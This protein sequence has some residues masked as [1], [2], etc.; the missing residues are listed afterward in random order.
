MTTTLVQLEKDLFALQNGLFVA[1]SGSHFEVMIMILK[2]LK[3]LRKVSGRRG[4]GGEGEWE[5]RGGGGR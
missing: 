4:G 2:R 1:V 5:E 3:K